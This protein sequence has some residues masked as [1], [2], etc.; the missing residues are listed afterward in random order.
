[1]LN[2]EP[3]YFAYVQTHISD[4]YQTAFGN[5]RFTGFYH[6]PGYPISIQD[7]I[8]R[9]DGAQ[10]HA[11]YHNDFTNRH[12]V[13]TDVTIAVGGA[14]L[15]GAQ[16]RV[17]AR[18]GIEPDG[19]GKPMRIY[20]AQVLDHFPTAD[21]WHRNCEKQAFILQPDITVAP[22]Q[23]V[24]V[25][26]DFTLD[27]DSLANPNNISIIV[28]AQ[29]PVSTTGNPPT[30][31]VYQAAIMKWPFGSLPGVGDMNCDGAFD[32]A[33]IEPFFLALAD[34]TAYHLAYPNCNIMNGDINN[35][36]AV[37]GADI[38]AFFDALSG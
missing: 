23:T 20:M 9:R 5:T 35:D 6:L 33:D 11:T 17:T 38:E 32:A 1:M 28:W 2:E 24:Q 3:V 19:T 37:D 18:I 7:G 12:N 13:K 15:D 14:H 30:A 31:E 4:G 36:G 10:T 26:H 22:G 25:T 27:T 34:P 16:Y 29:L 8:L 21:T